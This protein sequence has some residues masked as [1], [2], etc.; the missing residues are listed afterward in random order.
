V[1]NRNRALHGDTVILEILPESEWIVQHE[2]VQDFLQMNGTEEDHRTLLHKAVFNMK[3]EKEATADVTSSPALFGSLDVTIEVDAYNSPAPRG[4]DTIALTARTSAQ[5]STAPKLASSVVASSGGWGAGKVGTAVWD[6]SGVQPDPLANRIL[7]ACVHHHQ[8]EEGN[9]VK[10]SIQEAA[11][12]LPAAQRVPVERSSS[13]PVLASDLVLPLGQESSL[14]SRAVAL[15]G[16]SDSVVEEADES[17]YESCAS[18]EA[19]LEQKIE[20]EAFR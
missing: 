18:M 13:Q 19:D 16:L 2:T 3:Q 10:L 5:S 7:A 12:D 15:T 8:Q 4:P 17:D 20:D 14:E 11:V 1:R 6:T 9:G